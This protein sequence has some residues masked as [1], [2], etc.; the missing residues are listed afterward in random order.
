MAF[1]EI[2]FGLAA[3]SIFAVLFG[4]FWVKNLLKKTPIQ[5]DETENEFYNTL[6]PTE[7]LVYRELKNGFDSK[8]IASYTGIGSPRTVD[9]H[10]ANILKKAKC[11]SRLRFVALANRNEL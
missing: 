6:T 7:K 11:D 10:I 3:L 2:A 5:S 8:S 1:Q 4:F 9:N